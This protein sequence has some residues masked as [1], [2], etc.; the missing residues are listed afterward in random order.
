M[1]LERCQQK[2]TQKDYKIDTRQNGEACGVNM[3]SMNMLISIMIQKK[4]RNVCEFYESNIQN[5]VKQLKEQ[6]STCDNHQYYHM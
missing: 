2:I 1:I 5:E 4:S 3:K 6:T